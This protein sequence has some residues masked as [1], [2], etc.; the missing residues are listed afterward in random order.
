MR[1]EWIA[2]PVEFQDLRNNVTFYLINPLD[3]KPPNYAMP[4][5]TSEDF[6]PEQIVWTL[7][8]PWRRTN[9]WIKPECIYK[10]KDGS[11]LAG[12]INKLDADYF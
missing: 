11:Q 10:H 5:Y 9:P 4:H 2:E 12:L 6:P 1:G 7:Y 8:E 3:V